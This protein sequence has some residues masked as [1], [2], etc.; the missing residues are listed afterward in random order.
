MLL[1][2]VLCVLSA[3][4]SLAG[5]IVLAAGHDL[6]K[7]EAKESGAEAA[8]QPGN[9]AEKRR[10]TTGSQGD[11]ARILGEVAR[12]RSARAFALLAG[13]VTFLALALTSAAIDAKVAEP[14]PRAAA[15]TPSSNSASR[16]DYF[17]AELRNFAPD[18]ELRSK[19]KRSLCL[20]R[21]Y[22]RASTADA[23]RDPGAK[24][25]TTC[26][27][28][29]RLK[30]FDELYERLALLG[31]WGRRDTRVR[32]E[33]PAGTQI[34]HLMGRA[35]RQCD[36]GGECRGGGARQIL[37]RDADFRRAWFVR[38]ECAT[39]DERGRLKFSRCDG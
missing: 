5:A 1:V 39:G 29:R 18:P 12:Q 27:Q 36:P 21:Y 3:V 14:A 25:W 8:A 4:V 7:P 31:S 6:P 22:Q 38:T 23:P 30:T 34:D 24:W 13:A 10:G 9:A 15:A 19:L 2:T 11:A 33:V 28:S 26:E 16:D 37:F 17:A 20:V 32:A 35:S